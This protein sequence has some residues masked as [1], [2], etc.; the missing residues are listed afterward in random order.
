MAAKLVRI[1]PDDGT[2][3]Y[4]LPGTTADFSAEASQN[5][6][7]VFGSNFASNQT[8]LKTWSVSGDSLWRGIPGYCV[9]VKK[10]GT[11]TVFT[12]EAAAQ[13]GTTKEY[14]IVDRSKSVFD[15][16]TAVVVEDNASV[17][18]ATNIESINY[19]QGSVTF[20]SGYAVTGPV[21][22]TGAYL[23][24][25]AFGK[26]SSFD[27]TQTADTTDTT[28]FETACANGGW[29][30]MRPTLLTADLSLS[31]FYR[32]E[33]D[34]FQ[35]LNADDAFVIE[36][37][38]DGSDESVARGI[39]KLSS[40]SQSGD[41]G[42][43]ET[44]D[45]SFSLFVPDTTVPATPFGWRHSASS[46][47]NA[48]PV[49][50]EAWVNKTELKVQYLPNGVGSEGREGNVIVTDISASGSVEGLVTF[51]VTFDGTGA[52]SIVDDE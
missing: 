37:N 12:D 17:V 3:W 9:S 33:N 23:P 24:L 50:Q 8:G 7:S 46:I 13:I 25:A 29:A 36:I 28:D 38:P 39:Y 1:S 2:T 47:P 34:L 42:G 44:E 27:L 11:S 45:T 19:A 30:T 49:I 14:E 20:I 15:W 5:D 26:A 48:L 6:N 10:S 32:P 41:V 21:T 22:I 18:A 35:L 51:S 4:T 16:D 52:A 31:G 43:D 40:D